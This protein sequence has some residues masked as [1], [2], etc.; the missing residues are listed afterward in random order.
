MVLGMCQALCQLCTGLSIYI[1]MYIYINVF[2]K[3]FRSPECTLHHILM[4]M[5]SVLPSRPLFSAFS[6]SVGAHVAGHSLPDKL[7]AISKA[8][9]QGV[10][11]FQE[12]L[13]VFAASD[14]FSI[15][16]KTLTPPSSPLCVKEN[17]SIGKEPQYI[18]SSLQHSATTFMEDDM[19]EHRTEWN[20]MGPCTPMVAHRELVC[21]GYIG[22]LCRMLGLQVLALQP[23]RDVEGWIDAGKRD[24]AFRRVR[25]RFPIMRALGT[26][27][28]LICST[29]QGMP[30]TTGDPEKIA[31]DLAQLADEAAQFTLEHS[32]Q[33]LRIAFEALSWGAHIDHWRQ[34]YEVVKLAA[35][36]NL[37]LCLDSFNTLGR[38]FA[39]PCEPSGIQQP[40]SSTQQRLRESLN[41][42]ATRVDPSHVFFLQIGD[43]RKPPGGPLARSPNCEEPRPSRM[44]WSRSNRLFPGE[45]QAGA[46]LPVVDFVHVVVN[47]LGYDGPWSVEVFNDSLLE[48]RNDVPQTHAQRAFQGLCWLTEQIR[49]H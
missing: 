14:E 1:Y 21:A 12:D 18:D 37:G 28:L 30:E 32:D 20:A 26:D 9:I 4:D 8:G 25:S 22:G 38:E 23:M 43:A 11:I 19:S 13:D 39:D 2:M 45:V 29:N 15:L 3:S 24:Q 10:E 6:H 27:L 46:Y 41:A 48:T 34:A 49:Q 36:P 47:K 42:L 33:P 7:R 16:F 40:T 5:S 17:L 35:R 31:K 44:I